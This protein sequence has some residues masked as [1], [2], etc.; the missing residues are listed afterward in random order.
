MKFPIKDFFSKCDQILSFCGFGHIYWRNPQWKILFFVR[1][2]KHTRSVS[3]KILS[4]LI[5]MIFYEDDINKIFLH[6]IVQKDMK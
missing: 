6:Q 3:K 1:G 4:N 2:F 5:F